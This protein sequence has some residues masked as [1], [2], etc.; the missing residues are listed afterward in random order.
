[1][2]DKAKPPSG[3]IILQAVN[4]DMP[5]ANKTQILCRYYKGDVTE[6]KS[7]LKQLREF[8]PVIIA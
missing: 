3:F 5:A 2:I 7:I 1:M 8:F 4:K 6:R